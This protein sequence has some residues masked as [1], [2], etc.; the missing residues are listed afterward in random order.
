MAEIDRRSIEVEGIPGLTLMEQAGRSVADAARE[1]LTSTGGRRLAVFCGKGNNGG[2]GFVVARMLSG[3][4]DVVVFVAGDIS[5]MRNDARVNYERVSSMRIPVVRVTSDSDLDSFRR[6]PFDLVVDGLFGTGFAGRAEGVFS[7]VID[8]VNSSRCRVL[9]IDIPSGVSGATGAA[10]GPAIKAD[11]TVTFAALKVGLVQHPGA[12]LAGDVEVADIGI[13]AQV[14]DEVPDSRVYILDDEDAQELIPD[15]APDVNKGSCGHVLVVGGSSGMAGAP[16]M[17]ARAAVRSGS[18]LVTVAVPASL[19][20][21]LEIKLT[22]ELTLGLPEEKGSLDWGA[23][24]KLAGMSEKYDVIALGPG[25]GSDPWARDVVPGVLRSIELP[26]VLDA[27]GL[28]SIAGRAEVLKERKAPTVLTP[29]PGEMARLLG[30]NVADVQS[31]RVGC[32]RGAAGEW[33]VIIVLKG[34]GTVVASPDGEVRVNATGNPGMATGGMGD[35]LTGLIASLIGQ[36]A[37][38]FDAASAGAYLH[39]LSADLVASMDGMIG[40]T[41][42]DVIRHLPLAM[43]KPSTGR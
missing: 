12:W 4:F 32:A 33:G 37:T 11:R 29:H 28:N 6:A 7:D 26:I 15:R 39:G 14:L 38:P 24:E 34:A 30:T 3:G 10:Y 25:L 21:V 40:M 36:G 9:A 41:A 20:P 19:Q 31:D 16:A 18:G 43:R 23:V 5:T 22:E 35:V 1:M 42:G 13:P 8:A 2:D 17:C 27:D